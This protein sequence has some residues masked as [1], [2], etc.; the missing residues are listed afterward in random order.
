MFIY[1]CL[2]IKDSK[3]DSTMICMMMY[4]FNQMNC[5]NMH[6]IHMSAYHRNC[7]MRNF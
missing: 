5:L 3:K 6:E 7:E 4:E 1:T 2:K